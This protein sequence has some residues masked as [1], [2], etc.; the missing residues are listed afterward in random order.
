SFFFILVGA[1]L[2]EGT[3]HRIGL[4]APLLGITA[5]VVGVI[6]SLALFFAS[7]ALFNEH[8]DPDWFAFGIGAV[9][10]L[11]LTRWRRSVIEVVFGAAIVGFA[12]G[13]LSAL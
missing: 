13:Q 8:G 6:F 7:H 5:A 12:V 10:L 1:P 9:A 3:R 11:M 2:I 4:Q